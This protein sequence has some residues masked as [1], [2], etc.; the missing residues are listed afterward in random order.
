MIEVENL[1]KKYGPVTAVNGISFKVERG[2]ILGFLG[3]N[4]AGK[5]TTLRMLTCYV[6]PSEGT[7]RIAGYDIFY[8]SL[9]VRKRLGYLPE[10]VPLYTD[11]RVTDYLDF[12][13]RV[14]GIDPRELPVAIKQTV[15]KCG[16][17]NVKTKIIA[18]LSKGYRQRVGLAQALLG[19]PEVLMLDEPTT[20]LDPRQITEI[21]ELIKHLGIGHTVIVSTHI[22]PEV[23]MI[24]DRVIIINKGKLV[25]ADSVQN[26]TK[27][28]TK[29]QMTQINVKGEPQA[30]INALK[31][32][33]GVLAVDKKQELD[34]ADGGNVYVVHS[35]IDA[36]VRED[37][38]KAIVQGHFGLHEMRPY[39]LSLEDIFLM[40]TNE[41]TNRRGK[42]I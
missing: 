24:C 37:I 39:T 20:G 9:E 29:S 25:A 7:A 42:S 3:P 41:P 8:D 4:A 6:P 23:S 15:G 12:V 38:A 36:D 5:T 18:T 2:E 33:P 40:L 30:I 26:L 27:A 28:L 10:N 1:T 34:L 19:D 22:L 17:G 11:M 13:A 14:K 21:R 31:T 16:L 35:A 32:V